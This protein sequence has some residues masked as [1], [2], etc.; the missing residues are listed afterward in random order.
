MSEVVRTVLAERCACGDWHAFCRGVNPH[1]HRPPVAQ[2]TGGIF[3]RERIMTRMIKKVTPTHTF[4]WW[5]K[6]VSTAFIMVGLSI[7]AADYHTVL[8]MA[9]TLN[10]T[11]GWL[12]VAVIWH[13]RAPMIMNAAAAALLVMGI[14]TRL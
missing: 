6:W 3:L 2:V 4:D 8:D 14:L 13:D 1:T 5:L 11:I 9:L 10:G 12:I 7:R